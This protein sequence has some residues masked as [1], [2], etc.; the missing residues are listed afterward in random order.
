M[1]GRLTPSTA[2]TAAVSQSCSWL[3]SYMIV[4]KTH[5]S[6]SV[7]ESCA[8]A[9]SQFETPAALSLTHTPYFLLSRSVSVAVLL[10]RKN[11][12]HGVGGNLQARLLLQSGI[13]H[14][15]RALQP[16]VP[17]LDPRTTTTLNNTSQQTDR[18]TSGQ[19]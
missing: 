1:K 4:S 11:A 9:L 19:E 5:R 7:P 13:R 18:Y 15:I 8:R 16:L 12:S 2:E 10:S 14:L 3:C 17:R 6:E